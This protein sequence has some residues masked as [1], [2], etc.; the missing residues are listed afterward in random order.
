MP[1]HKIFNH[2]EII[3][4]LDEIFAEIQIMGLFKLLFLDICLVN[5]L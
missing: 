2:I 1:N 5:F 3:A 4:F